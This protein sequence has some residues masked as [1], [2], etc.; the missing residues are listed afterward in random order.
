MSNLEIASEVYGGIEVASKLPTGWHQNA[1]DIIRDSARI[2]LLDFSH[3]TSREDDFKGRKLLPTVVAAGRALAQ[4]SPWIEEFYRDELLKTVSSIIGENAQAAPDLNG[5]VTA[6]VLGVGMRFETHVDSWH[7]GANLYVQKSGNNIG[8]D[9]V[10]ARNLEARTYKQVLEDPAVT[11]V[12]KEGNLVVVKLSRR[13]HTVTVVGIEVDE[14]NK[15][16]VLK[17]RVFQI[18]NLNDDSFWENARI[19]LNFNLMLEGQTPEDAANFGNISSYVH[20]V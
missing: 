11:V 4:K 18:P 5:I 9:L 14:T 2:V 3:P 12:P 7:L 17:K 20:G 19:S 8:G 16:D 6:N 1:L 10:T 13:P 15:E